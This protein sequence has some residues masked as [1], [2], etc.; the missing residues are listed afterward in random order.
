[1]VPMPASVKSSISS[2]CGT[3]PLSMCT[4]RTPF[5]TDAMQASILGIMPPLIV[6]SAMSARA[7]LTLARRMRL[8]GSLTSASSP[9]TSVR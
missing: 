2:T 3:V 6:P 9:S 5:C 8:L 1:M 4:E 7:S